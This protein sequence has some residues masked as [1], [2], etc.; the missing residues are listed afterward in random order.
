MKLLKK[1]CDKIETSI[2][3]LLVIAAVLMIVIGLLQIIFR[4]VLQHSLS[5]SEETIRYLHVW[6]TTIGAAAVFYKGTFTSI[7][8]ISDILEK[9]SKLTGKALTVIRYIF[10]FIFYGVLLYQGFNLSTV[11]MKKLTA[12]TR[13]P[14]GIVYMCIPI[15]G[16]LGVIFNI[17]RLPEFLEKMKAPLPSSASVPEDAAQTGAS[18]SACTKDERRER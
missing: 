5:W 6:V 3:V 7:T 4:Y 1:I 2:N 10:P 9:K 18:L 14:M 12:A 13:I 15:T 11:Y 8:I 17:A 16:F